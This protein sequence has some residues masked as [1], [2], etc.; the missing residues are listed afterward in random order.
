MQRLV[1]VIISARR[2]R[3]ADATKNSM[4]SSTILYSSSSMLLLLLLLPLLSYGFIINSNN[5]N[6]C[7]NNNNVLI[8]TKTNHQQRYLST[9][10]DDVG[11]VDLVSSPEVEAWNDFTISPGDMVDINRM[12]VLRSD[13][14]T[15]FPMDTVLKCEKPGIEFAGTMTQRALVIVS[16]GPEPEEVMGGPSKVP[17]KFDL[18]E[19]E[20]TVDRGTKVDK[21]RMYV[22]MYE[23]NVREG[24]TVLRTMKPG[25]VALEDLS[26]TT[27]AEVVASSGPDGKWN[28][29]DAKNGA[30]GNSRSRGMVAFSSMTLGP[31]GGPGKQ[32]GFT[33]GSSS[34][35]VTTTPEEQQHETTGNS[36]TE[37]DTMLNIKEEYLK[38]GIIIVDNNEGQVRVSQQE[39]QIQQEQQ[40]ASEITVSDQF[41]DDFFEDL[42]QL[43]SLQDA[44]QSTTPQTT[45][46]PQSSFEST[47][48]PGGLDALRDNI[49]QQNTSSQQ[50]SDKDA[51]QSTTPQTTS[52]PQSS[53]E[54]PTEPGGLDA[55]REKIDQQNTSLQQSPTEPG[56]LDALREQFHQLGS[57]LEGIYSKQQPSKTAAENPPQSTA[58]AALTTSITQPLFNESSTTSELLLQDISTALEGLLSQ[59]SSTSVPREEV[60]VIQYQ[61]KRLEL[62]KDSEEKIKDTQSQKWEE[63]M[64]KMRE[65]VSYRESRVLGFRQH[66]DQLLADYVARENEIMNLIEECILGQS[67]TI[68]TAL[69]PAILPKEAVVEQPIHNEKEVE[70]EAQRPIAHLASLLGADQ[71]YQELAKQQK[72]DDQKLQLDQQETT[73]STT[74][75][76]TSTWDNNDNNQEQEKDLQLAVLE[77]PSSNDDLQEAT[78][79]SFSPFGGAKKQQQNPF[80]G[81][82]LSDL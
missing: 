28:E 22:L 32:E 66:L 23:K 54:S 31:T 59:S 39:Q 49:D 14:S 46:F 81:S 27:L 34:K 42:E 55:L 17:K 37:G 45:S 1:E 70:E 36:D 24:G 4:V 48:E 26:M 52:F 65:F 62:I 56:G 61:I 57:M 7:N 75:V 20:Y 33:Y 15:N 19:N 77:E 53:F 38:D 74:D 67:T 30:S 51:T 80:G 29:E 9:L 40:S 25:I 10:T 13:Y 72:E 43:H 64:E 58:S 73:S 41:P 79:A 21:T 47:T 44:T 82:Y 12:E 2:R 18:K 69:I 68:P 50:Y 5:N 78:P 71:A 76:M 6:F 8:R 11:N 63:S 60:E 35:D 16:L 3:R